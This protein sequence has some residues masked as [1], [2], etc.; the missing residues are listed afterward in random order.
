MSSDRQYSSEPTGRSGTA[1]PS[2]GDGEPG[3]P[4]AGG[5][6]GRRLR[7]ALRAYNEEVALRMQRAGSELRATHLAVL[8]HLDVEGTR[9]T[10]LARRAGLSRQAVTQVLDELERLGVVERRPDP[11]DRRAKLVRYTPAGLL[12]LGSGQRLSRE[13][14]REFQRRVGAERLQEALGVLR[15][16]FPPSGD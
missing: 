10:A 3:R 8:S 9:Q 2:A 5:E 7:W 16:L 15:E 11:H 13:L 14:E 1:P 12:E 4:L 6:L